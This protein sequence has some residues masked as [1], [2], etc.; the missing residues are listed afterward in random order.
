MSFNRFIFPFLLI[1][2]PMDKAMA[3]SGEYGGWHMWP[4]MMGTWGMGGFGLVFMIVFW[5]LVIVALVF[6]I[7]WLILSTRDRRENPYGTSR[8]LDI[9]K[10]RYA[11]GEIDKAEFEE[12]KRDLLD[13]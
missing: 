4:G 8:P 12:K 2:F 7:K 11:R 6:L 13:S 9:L 10:E 3:Q 5:G 1:L